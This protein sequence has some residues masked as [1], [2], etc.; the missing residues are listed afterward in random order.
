MRAHGFDPDFSGAVHQQLETIG[1]QPAAASGPDVRDLR[2]T[3]WSSIDNDTSRDLDQVEAAERLP[4]GDIRVLVGIADVDAFV[5]IRSPID[6][7]A[8]IQTTT[9]YAGVRI[10]PML[11]ET[12]STG[13][14][15]L[16]EGA[17][18]LAI[19]I[20]FT[21]AADGAVRG[22]QVYR[23]LIRNQAQL[24]YNAVGAWL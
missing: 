8:S 24:T 1:G 12:L 9:V 7:H 19:V 11:P 16:L 10:F 18:K 4:N 6:E 14:T 13:T 23:A 3:L 22:E 2:T 17:D 5:P 21:V 15:S 20:E